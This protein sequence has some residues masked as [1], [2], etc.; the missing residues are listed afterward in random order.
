MTGAPHEQAGPIGPIAAIDTSVRASAFWPAPRLLATFRVIWIE[1]AIGRRSGPTTWMAIRPPF[2]ASAPSDLPAPGSPLGMITP[3]WPSR[4]ASSDANKIASSGTRPTSESRCHPPQALSD[5]A[6]SIKDMM[7]SA[8]G[9]KGGRRKAKPR[10][11]CGVDS[12]VAFRFDPDKADP[13]K[14]LIAG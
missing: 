8:I 2:S 6:A 3:P 13:S 12:P 5:L 14:S 10:H 7:M 11:C 9:S 1:V 4:S